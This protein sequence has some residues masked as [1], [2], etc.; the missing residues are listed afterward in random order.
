MSSVSDAQYAE[1]DGSI[2]ISIIGVIRRFFMGVWESI[3]LHRA[4][5]ML[6]QD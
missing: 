6:H 1:P 5:R 3:L 4:F 2:F